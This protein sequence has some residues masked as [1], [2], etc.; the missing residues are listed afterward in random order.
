MTGSNPENTF[1]LDLNQKNDNQNLIL[2]IVVQIHNLKQLFWSLKISFF[3]SVKKYENNK[4]S[5]QNKNKN[6]CDIFFLLS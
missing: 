2:I 6:Y 3:I 5:L 1:T 4:K